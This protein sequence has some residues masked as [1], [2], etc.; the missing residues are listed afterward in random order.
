MPTDDTAVIQKIQELCQ[1]ILEQRDR[2]SIRA[3][4]DAF[5]ADDSARTQYHQWLTQAAALERQQQQAAPISPD[6]LAEFETRR[7]AMLANPV[8][9]AFL[10]ARAELHRIQHTINQYISKTLE[11]GRVATEQDFA[12][13]CCGHDCGC[14]G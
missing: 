1:A 12:S 3:R 13:E 8:A 7:A 4:I 6:A 2:T 14:H 10:E 11:L 5:M 9:V